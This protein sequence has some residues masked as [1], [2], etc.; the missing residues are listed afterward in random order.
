MGLEDNGVRIIIQE[1][2]KSFIVIHAVFGQWL[3]R[4]I[5]RPEYSF[6]KLKCIIRKPRMREAFSVM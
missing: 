1:S 3:I 4:L 5:R 2:I 6:Q